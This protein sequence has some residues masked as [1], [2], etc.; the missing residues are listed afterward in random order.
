[1]EAD[2]G[3]TTPE[4]A[5]SLI[6]RAWSEYGGLDILLNNAGI[7]RRSPAT[8]MS[9]ADWDD[10]IRLDLS[11]VFYL[12][13][14]AGHRWAEHPAPYHR[15]IINL[16]SMLSFQGGFQVASY[17]AAKSG[18][19]GL[20]RALANEWAWRGINVNAI[21]PGYLETEVTAGI[22]ADPEREAAVRARV[23]AGRWGRPSDIQG[24]L[25]FLASQA[26]DYIHGAVLP[27]DGGWLSW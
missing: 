15:K 9:E 5:R 4:C 17:A 20:T 8:A 21:A 7:I 24:A 23:P 14:A 10:V 25:V 18:V 2:L 11:A 19:A 1:L 26:A 16:A 12:S 22:R 13:Q 6:D 3:Q 27:V